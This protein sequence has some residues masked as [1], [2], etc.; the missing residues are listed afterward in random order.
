MCDATGEP[1]EPISDVSDEGDGLTLRRRTFLFLNPHRMDL[2]AQGPGT[3]RCCM[4]VSL[5]RVAYWFQVAIIGLVT[6]NLLLVLLAVLP[7]HSTAQASSSSGQYATLW[8]AAAAM[9]VTPVT[10][11]S[12]VVFTSEYFARLW[13]CPELS[14][15]TPAWKI[16]SDWMFTYLSVVELAALVLLWISVLD[17]MEQSTRGATTAQSIRAGKVLRALRASGGAEVTQ[18][19]SGSSLALGLVSRLTRARRLLRSST[20]LTTLDRA[21]VE[22]VCAAL[23]AASLV[24]RP[25]R[26]RDKATEDVVKE[27]P[28]EGDARPSQA[29]PCAAEK[30]LQGRASPRSVG[31]VSHLQTTAASPHLALSPASCEQYSFLE[32]SPARLPE[33]ASQGLWTDALL[34]RSPGA[35]PGGFDACFGRT[36]SVAASAQ[37]PD[38]FVLRRNAEM[39]QQMLA[40]EISAWPEAEVADGAATA[41]KVFELMYDAGG[42]ALIVVAPFAEFGKLEMKCSDGGY[43]TQR[44]KD[45]HVSTPEF[46]TIFREF[47]A[48]SDSD[49]WP[50]F[51]DDCDAR[52]KPKDGAILLAA[53]GFRAKCA[54]KILRI[55]APTE[56]PSHGTRHEA[57]LFIAAQLE[58]AVVFVRSDGG[59]MHC[60]LA[61]DAGRKALEVDSYG[62][63]MKRSTQRWDGQDSPHYEVGG[64]ARSPAQ[65]PAKSLEHTRVLHEPV[66]IG[67]AMVTEAQWKRC[68]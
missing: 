65:S 9:L 6:L 40:T 22:E 41:L 5:E 47:T 3:A 59:T 26:L 62:V 16:R 18:V 53:S 24:T 48:H 61:S 13:S 63:S 52:G 50:A 67:G 29:L 28:V 2:H 54:A 19:L 23:Q 49:R 66:T 12:C 37:R 44:L 17:P 35:S 51:H 57:A 4:A 60:L 21:R 43:L 27:P 11:C 38:V 31:F 36:A 56:W 20:K 46:R 64:W 15:S 10:C 55:M 34:A 58:N 30:P 7:I 32:D 39:V 8:T 1:S 68:R 45:V 42:G 14:L 25:V 33:V